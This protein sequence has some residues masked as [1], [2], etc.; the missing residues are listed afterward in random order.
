VIQRRCADDT[1]ADD[2]HASGCWKVCHDVIL[3]TQGAR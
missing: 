3:N 1:A 2:D